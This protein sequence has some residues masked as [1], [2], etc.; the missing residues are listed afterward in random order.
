MHR[1]CGM[2]ML[3]QV[4]EGRAARGLNGRG[5][6]RQR[7]DPRVSLAQSSCVPASLQYGVPPPSLAP[8]H[9]PAAQPGS[10][11]FVRPPHTG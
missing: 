8:A 2:P 3:P 1:E 5:S 10:C 7:A 9:D 11:R 6:V 4:T